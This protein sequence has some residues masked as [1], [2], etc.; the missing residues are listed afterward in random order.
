MGS[1]LPKYLE[2]FGCKL[3]VSISQAKEESLGGPWQ[4]LGLCGQRTMAPVGFNHRFKHRL[5]YFIRQQLSSAVSADVMKGNRSQ[6]GGSRTSS[7]SY[8]A[9][10]LAS[11]ISCFPPLLLLS[12]HR[13]SW[14]HKWPSCL[15]SLLIFPSAV[16][17]PC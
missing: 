16:L 7:I 15:L 4:W 14:V 2:N 10:S 17:L 6:A 1:S 12:P 3:L 9:Q 13:G 11:E 5:Q 8:K